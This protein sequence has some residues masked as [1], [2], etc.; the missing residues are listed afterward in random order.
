[1]E[2]A[3]AV[4]SWSELVIVAVVAAIVILLIWHFPKMRGRK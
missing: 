1:V 3:V 4:P 2:D